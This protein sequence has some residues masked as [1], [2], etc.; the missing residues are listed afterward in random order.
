MQTGIY[1]W[2]CLQKQSLAGKIK[3]LLRLKKTQLKPRDQ[4]NQKGNNSNKQTYK[5]TF[6]QTN[7][8]QQMGEG[9]EEHISLIWS[10]YY[11]DMVDTEVWSLT[12]DYQNVY[13]DSNDQEREMRCFSKI[14]MRKT[15]SV[16]NDWK[17]QY[18]NSRFLLQ[19]DRQ[20][21][22]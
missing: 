19:T 10:N 18:C 13:K 3:I 9:K 5:Q 22:Q 6:K 20:S 4:G 16:I 1:S 14:M 12:N 2:F 8:K 11:D 15:I 21:E 17:P 7:L